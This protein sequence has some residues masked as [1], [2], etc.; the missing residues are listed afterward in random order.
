MNIKL[1]FALFV[2]FFCPISILFA[3]DAM[4][5]W[6]DGKGETIYSNTKPHSNKEIEVK[7]I[8]TTNTISKNSVFKRHMRRKDKRNDTTDEE[9]EKKFA[10]LEIAIPSLPYKKKMA[11]AKL[12]KIIADE[13]IYLEA[14]YKN[15][16]NYIEE[17]KKRKKYFDSEMKSERAQKRFWRPRIYIESEELFL[18]RMDKYKKEIDVHKLILDWAT[19]KMKFYTT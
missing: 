14:T 16:S 19:K 6:V 3:D 7:K 2:L 1:L 10:D 8:T 5:S 15:S 11:I 9:F 12:N 17:Y 4:F 18:K 13:K